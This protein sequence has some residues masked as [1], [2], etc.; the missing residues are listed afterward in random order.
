MR[1]VFIICAV[2]FLTA[3][4]GTGRKAAIT[5]GEL[6]QITGSLAS[7]KFYGRGTGT[8]GD[9]LAALF[10]R[11]ELEKAGAVP[12]TGTGLQ[13]FRVN[14]AV[15]AG[16]NNRLSVSGREYEAGAD[17]MPLALSSNS[18]LAAPVAFCGYGLLPSGDTLHRDDFAGLDLTG[19]WAMVLRGFPES[20]PGSSGYG[21]ISTDRIKVLNARDK[22]AAGVLLVSG[23]KWD[24]ADNLDKPSRSEA[25]AGLPVIHV[26]RS[27][28]D[29]ILK[30]SELT[31]KELEERSADSKSPAGLM[32]AT[33]VDA[34]ADVEKKEAVT[35][36]VVMKLEGNSNAEEYVIIGAHYD[37]LGMGGPGSSSRVPDTVAVHY[38]ADDNASGVA[39]MIEL[40]ERLAASKTGHSRSIV[41][42]AFSG[43]EMGLLGSKHF[44]ENG[45]IEPSAIDLMINLDMVGRM[46]EGNGLQVG[47]VGT[48]AGLRETVI[49]NSDT[50]AIRLSFT[51][52][53]YGPSDHSS[54]YGKNIP[55]LYFT[56]GAHL[57]YHTPQDTPDKLNY[58][59]MVR[60]GDLLS[61]IVSSAASRPA[62]LAFTEA[63]PKEPSGPQKR[64]HSRDYARLC[65]KRHQ[66][67]AG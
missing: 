40:A 27:V 64:C 43:E 63:G 53:G 66:R 16:K 34:M 35:S 52:E 6:S 22:G 37:H 13:S 57:D 39:L 56:T 58:E 60:I 30:S 3:C 47:G 2:I 23:E 25:R 24:V 32:T 55:V 19:K 54:F 31:L 29:S 41:F 4:A 20:D 21:S 46:K 59:G 10:I 17:F 15:E 45:G 36:N 11:K 33:I 5:P 28:A 65:R 48:A 14:V 49:A 62:R 38:G 26:R 44:V 67:V 50:S 18:S 12:F 1:I 42:V 51:S 7:D 61:G 8:G 9:S